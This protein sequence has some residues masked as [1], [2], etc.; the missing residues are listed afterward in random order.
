[1]RTVTPELKKK[2]DAQSIATLVAFRSRHKPDILPAWPW[3]MKCRTLVYETEAFCTKLLGEQARFT[4]H[5]FLRGRFTSGQIDG[6]FERGL[7]LKT[8]LSDLTYSKSQRFPTAPALMCLAVTAQFFHLSLMNSLGHNHQWCFGEG[9]VL[10]IQRNCKPN[11]KPS[12]GYEKIMITQIL[13]CIIPAEAR[14]R[15][16]SCFG[17]QIT[18]F[19][20]IARLSMF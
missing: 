13:S 16:G 11:N 15:A 18:L 7:G 4:D 3:V 6:K 14:N 9:A 2:E 19:T 10:L 5:L 12:L 17:P 1:M 20:A 8:G